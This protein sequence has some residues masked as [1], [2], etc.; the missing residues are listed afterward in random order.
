MLDE[1]EPSP[2]AASY[3]DPEIRENYPNADLI[4]ESIADAGPRPL[5]PFYVDVAGSVIQTWHPPESV[6]AETPSETDSFMADVLGGRR[7][8]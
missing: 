4:R 8:L 5:T 1:G 3:N 7:M 2:Y 6:T